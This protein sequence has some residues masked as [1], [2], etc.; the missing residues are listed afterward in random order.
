MRKI[1]MLSVV[2][3][4][5]FSTAFQAN[6]LVVPV[7]TPSTETIQREAL[8]EWNSLSR[9]EKK[10][11]IK[12]AKKEIKNFKREKRNGKDADENTILLVVL[13]I[14]IPPLAV[15]LHQGEINTKFWISLILTLLLWLPGAIYSLLVVLGVV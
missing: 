5:L 14:I 12:E 13:A 9:K 1:I 10:E 2:T 4:F 6:A 15:Y 11:R 8:N 7:S 3:A